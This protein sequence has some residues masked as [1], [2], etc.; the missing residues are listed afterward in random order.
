[1]LRSIL[2]E[3]DLQN[4]V[5]FTVFFLQKNFDHPNFGTLAAVAVVYRSVVLFIESSQEKP[6]PNSLEQR[7]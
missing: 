5:Q 2:T 3:T 6:S 7:L 1:M 4:L